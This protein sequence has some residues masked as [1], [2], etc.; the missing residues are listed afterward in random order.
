MISKYVVQMAGLFSMLLLL[1]GCGG[2]GGGS[3][4]T[5]SVASGPAGYATCKSTISGVV[6][7]CISFTG[8]YYQSGTTAASACTSPN[9]TF[10]P[11]PGSCPLTYSVGTCAFNVGTTTAAAVTMYLTAYTVAMAQNSCGQVSGTYTNP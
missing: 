4:T 3:S 5:S 7:S 9:S 6:T 8:S 2:G 1:G 10:S 11:T